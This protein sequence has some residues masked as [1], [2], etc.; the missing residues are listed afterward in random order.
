M[1]AR[2]AHGGEPTQRWFTIKSPHFYVHYYKS[3]RHDEGAQAQKVARVAERCHRILAPIFRHTPSSRTHIVVTDMTDG[4]NGMAQTLPYNIIHVY[5]TGPDS[6]SYL[7]LYDD[8]LTALIMHEY[9][10]ILHLDT[11]H[12]LPTVVNSVMGKVWAPNQMQPR[13]FLEGLA[14]HQETWRTGGGRLRSSLFD[15]LLRSHAL[16]GKLL[17]LDQISSNTRIYPRGHVPYVYGA[18]FLN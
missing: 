6:H 15:M 9:T 3:L 16:E 11:I 14:V 13:W 17:R 10:H 5:L 12:G 18:F 7:Q 8:W 1:P 4:A 2:I